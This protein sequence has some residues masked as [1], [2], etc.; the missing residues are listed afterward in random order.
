MLFHPPP[1]PPT[2]TKEPRTRDNMMAFG[3]T[4]TH[5][6]TTYIL[7]VCGQRYIIFAQTSW[8]QSSKCGSVLWAKHNP[9]TE[10]KSSQ[11]HTKNGYLL[12]LS[13]AGGS[14]LWVMWVRRGRL[15]LI[16]F[17]IKTKHTDISRIS[18]A[19]IHH[20]HSIYTVKYIWLIVVC[21]FS[22]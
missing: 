1:K 15:A 18:F 20:H 5:M 14:G 6:S 10:R 4:H 17:V 13:S 11:K 2:L 12:L 22:V 16:G 7:G 19:F 3:R 9:H 8:I 21:H